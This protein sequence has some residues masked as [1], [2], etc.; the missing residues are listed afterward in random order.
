MGTLQS[1]SRYIPWRSDGPG[2]L[3]C[4]HSSPKAEPTQTSSS[5][6][7]CG[8]FR[9]AGWTD[10]GPFTQGTSPQ[11]RGAVRYWHMLQRGWTPETLRERNRNQRATCQWFRFSNA[12]GIDRATETGRRPEVAGSGQEED[13]AGTAQRVRVSL[14]G[15][16]KEVGGS[17]STVRMHC[18]SELFVFSFKCEFW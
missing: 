16:G 3:T 18:D 10:C 4:T 14:W 15:D 5:E 12:S 7:P 1:P 2:Q 9:P 11:P 6:D 17:H 13:M 8:A